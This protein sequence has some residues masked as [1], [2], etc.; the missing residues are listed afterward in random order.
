MPLVIQPYIEE[1]FK[2]MAQN[3]CI[4]IYPYIYHNEFLLDLYYYGVKVELSKI[5]FRKR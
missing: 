4:F 3:I 5:K 2:E 1:K